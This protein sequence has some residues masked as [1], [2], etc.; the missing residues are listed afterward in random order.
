MGS[1]LPHLQAWNTV[2]GGVGEVS[3]GARTMMSLH[4]A[5]QWGWESRWSPGWVPEREGS[6]RAL[7]SPAQTG[8]FLCTELPSPSMNANAIKPHPAS[9]QDICFGGKL[10]SNQTPPVSVVTVQTVI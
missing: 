9:L 7:S 8:I 2:M 6:L 10:V 4:R 3:Q 5:G 1:N